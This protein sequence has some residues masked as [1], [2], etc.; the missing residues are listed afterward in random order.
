[1]GYMTVVSFL[2]DG[3]S[4]FK[5]HPEQV[6]DNIISGGMGVSNGR[7]LHRAVNDYPVGN[8]ANPMEVAQSFHADFSQV[9]LAG[10]NSMTMLTDWRFNNI[11]DMEFQLSRIKEAKRLLTKTEKS[12]KENLEKLKKYKTGVKVKSLIEIPI[13]DKFVC[14]KGDICAIVNDKLPE[15]ISLLTTDSHCFMVKKTEVLKNFEIIE[16]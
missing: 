2:N 12:L 6:I 4:T 1:M 7:R 3:I 8:F 15:M 14:K 5:E 9:F 10:Q 11:N 16:D 13:T